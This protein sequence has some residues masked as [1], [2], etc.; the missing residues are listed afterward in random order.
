MFDT[1]ILHRTGLTLAL[2]LSLAACAQRQSPPPAQQT[3]GMPG[4]GAHQGH[5]MRAMGGMQGHNMSG[6]SMEQMAAHCAQMRQQTRSGAT[7]SGDMRAMMTHC[8]QMHPQA[9]PTGAA[10]AAGQHRH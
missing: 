10:P 7:M 5:D 9:G 2:G 6:M 1:R 3:G 4:M 8:D